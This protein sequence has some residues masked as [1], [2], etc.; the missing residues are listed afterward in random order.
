MSN[1]GSRSDRMRDVS[2]LH[3]DTCSSVNSAG[4]QRKG[5]SVGGAW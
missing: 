4:C 2:H 1:G 5:F 3:N